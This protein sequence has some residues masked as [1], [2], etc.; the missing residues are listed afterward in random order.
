MYHALNIK[1]LNFS[2]NQDKYYPRDVA[3][4]HAILKS[5]SDAQS[6]ALSKKYQV[7]CEH[8]ALIGKVQLTDTATGT[9]IEMDPLESEKKSAKPPEE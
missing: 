2:Q 7:V 5:N 6:I 8:T 4:H 9:I 3:A 1:L